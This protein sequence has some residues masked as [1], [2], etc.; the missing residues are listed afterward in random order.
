MSAGAYAALNLGSHVGDDL[1]AVEE[2]RRVLMA[3]LGLEGAALLVP[4]QVHGTDLVS[5]SSSD[6]AALSRARTKAVEGADGL[7]VAAP[8]VAALLCFADC[9]GC[10]RG[11]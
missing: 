8:N 9:A 7:V 1:A 11:T 4:S 6:A 5:V 10:P 2:N 3:A